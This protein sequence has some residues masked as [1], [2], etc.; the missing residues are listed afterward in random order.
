VG[1]FCGPKVCC[2]PSLN[3]RLFISFRVCSALFLNSQGQSFRLSHHKIPYYQFNTPP[4]P[5][6]SRLSAFANFFRTLNTKPVPIHF[7]FLFL[8]TFLFSASPFSKAFFSL[9]PRGTISLVLME[10]NTSPCIAYFCTFPFMSTLGIVKLSIGTPP[11]FFFFERYQ[12]TLRDGTIFPQYIPSSLFAFT[13]YPQ[14]NAISCAK[15]SHVSQD[16][17]SPYLC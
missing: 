6:N 14:P 3:C 4:T 15:P 13:L 1:V 17:F 5:V 2:P 7:L 10:T 11:A 16:H 9:V 12:P 8:S